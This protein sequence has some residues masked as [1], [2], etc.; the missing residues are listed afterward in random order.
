MFD[1]LLKMLWV[2]NKP[3]FWT[4]HGYICKDYAEFQ[5]YLIMVPWASIMIWYAS[6]CLNTPQY[7]WTWLNIAEG[8][9]KCLNNPN[10][11]R[12]CVGEGEGQKEREGEGE[13]KGERKGE[14]V[15]NF[16]TGWFSLNNSKMV[17]AV[18]LVFCSIQ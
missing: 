12:I 7:A 17:K 9:W 8:P 18:T 1:R 15:R 4:C 2:L 13:L 16:T 11:T 3:G 5:V 6:L 10:L 14:G